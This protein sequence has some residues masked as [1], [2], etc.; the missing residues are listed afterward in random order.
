MVE[1]SHSPHG[2][3]EAGRDERKGPG[4]RSHTASGLP[5]KEAPPSH[6]PFRMNVSMDESIDEI[7]T[8]VIQSPLNSTTSWGPDFMSKPYQARSES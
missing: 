4:T 6:S 1:Q 2:S 8:L 7:S 5:S 3:Q